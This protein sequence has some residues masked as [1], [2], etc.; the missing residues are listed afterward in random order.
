MANDLGN[1][2]VQLLFQHIQRSI[3]YLDGCRLLF[4]LWQGALVHL[5][6]LV[7]RDGLNLHGDGRHHIRWLLVEDEGVE[8]LD[9]Y[10]LI[11]DDIRSNELAAIFMVEGLH[12]SILD[13]WEFADDSLYLFQLDTEATNLYLSVLTAYKL[14]VAVRQVAY[15]VTGLVNTIVFRLIRK[16]VSDEHLCRLFRTVQIATPHLRTTDP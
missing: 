12:G 16:R 3:R 9:V 8:C 5:L 15:D 7:E 14:D 2:V 4:R 1:D 13:A 6:V 11:A 10:L